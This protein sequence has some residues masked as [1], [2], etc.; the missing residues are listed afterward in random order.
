MIRHPEDAD[1]VHTAE[2]VLGRAQ[3]TMID[4]VLALEVE[5]G[6]HDVL[7]RLWPRD[8]AAFR[9]VSDDE[10]GRAALLG[11]S[12]EPRGA[13]ANLPDVSRRAL[14]ITGEQGLDGVHDEHVR[15]MRLGRC[16]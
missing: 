9:D 15:A 6:V 16:E 3:D 10:D 13:L 2:A 12:H 8:A 4:A 7:E 5:H 14:Q 1:L 11:E